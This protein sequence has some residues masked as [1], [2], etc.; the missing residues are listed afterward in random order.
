MEGY[1]L[2]N[3]IL[4]MSTIF[5]VGLIPFAVILVTAFGKIAIV[6][7]IVRNALGLQQ[8]PPNIVLYGGA[9]VLS[10]YIMYPVLDQTVA[11]L[12]LSNI[13]PSDISRW[14]E[15]YSVGIEPIREFLIQFARPEEREFFVTTTERLWA[16]MPSTDIKSDDIVI[17]LPSFF[18]GELSRAFQIGFLI[19]LPMIAIDF[20]V[21]NILMAMGMMMV[22]PTTI[23]LP[24]KLLIFVLA[25]GWTR[26]MHGLVLSYIV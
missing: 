23:A 24:F 25:D 13:D 18:V 26:L 16:S 19:F 11:A 17:L 3:P 6:L 9:L 14:G 21:A 22:S 8:T 5:A 4:M 15:A 12:Q 1:N 7:F 10:V 2:P 20:I